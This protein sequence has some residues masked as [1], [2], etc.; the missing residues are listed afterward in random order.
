MVKTNFMIY[1]NGRGL[2]F[3]LGN[4]KMFIE[5]DRDEEKRQSDGQICD[6]HRTSFI[7][8]LFTSLWYYF[9]FHISIENHNLF[10]AKQAIKTKRG[11]QQTWTQHLIRVWTAKFIFKRHYFYHDLGLRCLICFLNWT[12]V[13]EERKKRCRLFFPIAVCSNNK[14]RIYN[15]VVT[16]AARTYTRARKR[17]K[18]LHLKASTLEIKIE[19]RWTKRAKK[20]CIGCSYL[21]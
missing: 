14:K 19:Q 16:V 18:T 13:S 9:F 5:N 17:E 15:W 2:S 7:A 11:D 4:I 8:L 12:C 3:R 6:K 10:I 1:N 20:K 21:I